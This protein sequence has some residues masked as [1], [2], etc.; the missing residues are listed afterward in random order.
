M[1]DEKKQKS[2]APGKALAIIGFVFSIVALI[3]KISYKFVY[4]ILL[5]FEKDMLTNQYQDKYDVLVVDSSL[6]D[7]IA[8]ICVGLAT[9]IAI[10]GLLLAAI[11]F[12]VFLAKKTDGP[13]KSFPLVFSIIAIA[14]CILALLV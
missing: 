12:I 3:T 5:E 7:M 6:S 9:F 2:S 8:K 10:V 14:L 4:P 1:V 11:G 13:K